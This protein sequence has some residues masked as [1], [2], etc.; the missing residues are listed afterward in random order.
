MHTT[1]KKD[2]DFLIVG[3]G[4]AGSML[5]WF[6]AAEN[7]TFRVVDVIKPNSASRVAAG[8]MNPVTGR[9]FVK[10]WKVDVLFPFA[11][12]TYREMGA[13][14]GQTF[15]HARNILRALY[16]HVEETAW[17]LRTGDPAYRHYIREPARLAEFEGKVIPARSWCELTGGGQVDVAELVDAMRGFLKAKD[18]LDDA[19]F[20]FEKLHIAENY[21]EYGSWRA[22]KVVFCEGIAGQHN[23]WFGY[24]P[25]LGSKG[26]VL[27]VRMPVE[28]FHRILKHKVFVVPIR[29]DQYWVGSFYD[30]EDPSESPTEA[31]YLNLLDKLRASLQVPFEVVEHRAAIRPTVKDRR[32]FLG[33]HPEFPALAIF[34]G[35]GTKG[36]SL[37][38]FF[39]RQMTRFLLH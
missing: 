5:A 32:P 38:P 21:V 28:P 18:C 4:L 3:Q 14:F 30:R 29:G 7:R 12:K 39:A 1:P 9:R 10:S 11:Q 13:H 2:I 17:L 33:L 15:F 34:N 25:F 8:L 31:G 20:D 27:I 19:V 22:Q 36:A 26:E 23:P 24:L 37:A 16:N 35:L 6:L